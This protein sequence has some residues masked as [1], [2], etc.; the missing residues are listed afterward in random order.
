MPSPKWRNMKITTYTPGGED[1]FTPSVTTVSQ[2]K[3]LTCVLLTCAELGA[4]GSVWSWHS[5]SSAGLCPHRGCENPLSHW[6]K[7]SGNRWDTRCAQHRHWTLDPVHGRSHCSKGT[8][9]SPFLSRI[10]PQQGMFR[11]VTWPSC[12]EKPRAGWEVAGDLWITRLY[13]PSSPRTCNARGSN[14]SCSDFCWKVKERQHWN[15][16]PATAMVRNGRSRGCKYKV[17]A[18]TNPDRSNFCCS[19]LHCFFKFY[20]QIS[21]NTCTLRAGPLQQRF[22]R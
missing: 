18:Y 20:S 6:V 12:W 2:D 5:R 17:L 3:L 8:I 7:C 15:L 10:P 16:S 4:T 22:Q 11:K 14:S 9:N 19:Y 21:S 13:T 1:Q